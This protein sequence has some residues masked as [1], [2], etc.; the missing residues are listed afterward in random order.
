MAGITRKTRSSRGGR[1]ARRQERQQSQA[2]R[3]PYIRRQL[4]PYHIL[5]EE[6]LCLIEQQADKILYEIGMEFRDDPE[7]LAVFKNHGCDVGRT[8]AF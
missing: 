1:N 3:A 2:N 4:A 5:G 7:V 8:G 6:G